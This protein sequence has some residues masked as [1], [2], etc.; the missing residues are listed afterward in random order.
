MQCPAMP[1][2]ADD[3]QDAWSAWAADMIDLY[4]DCAKRHRALGDWARGR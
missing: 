4:V 1:L 3:S 2:P